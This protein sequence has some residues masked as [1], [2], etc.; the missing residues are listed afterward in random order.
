[1]KKYVKSVVCLAS[2]LLLSGFGVSQAWAGLACIPGC[3]GFAF[4]AV[5]VFWGTVASICNPVAGIV[6]GL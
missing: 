4:G 5:G 6:V 2:V 3:Q 1:M